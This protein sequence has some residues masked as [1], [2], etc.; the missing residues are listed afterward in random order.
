[1]KLSSHLRLFPQ[2]ITWLKEMD[3]FLNLLIHIIKLLLQ[4]NISL[5]KDKQG[6][7]MDF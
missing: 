4:E 6:E 2:K 7:G 1:M 3:I 5:L